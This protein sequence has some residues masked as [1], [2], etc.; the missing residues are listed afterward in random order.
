MPEVVARRY[1]SLRDGLGW[2]RIEE[3]SDGGSS[4]EAHVAPSEVRR[5][6]SLGEIPEDKFLRWYDCLW[7]AMVFITMDE[8]ER[9]KSGGTRFTRRQIL[10]ELSKLSRLKP[11]AEVPSVPPWLKGE[12]RS[13]EHERLMQP[14]WGPRPHRIGEELAPFL[15]DCDR[16][17]R[18]AALR[19]QMSS[20]DASV[21][22][23]LARDLHEAVSARSET[24][25]EY[26]ARKRALDPARSY[27]ASS[28]LGFWTSGLGRP[29]KATKPLVAMTSAVYELCHIDMS[30]DA[31]KWQLREAAKDRDI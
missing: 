26:Y 22:R 15:V 4:H 8:A 18:E 9:D 23:E 21:M 20:N 7:G 2:L 17:M 31:V 5:I 30:V 12:M 24:T 3:E 6:A 14:K 1:H 28:I 19:V 25:R 10:S 16:A 11:D 27:I 13:L 29:S